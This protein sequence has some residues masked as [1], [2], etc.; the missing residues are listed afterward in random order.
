MNEGALN[1]FALNGPPIS[2]FQTSIVVGSAFAAGTVRLIG[3]FRSPEDF[4]VAAEQAGT[5]GHLLVRNVGVHLAEAQVS[6]TVR[7]VVRSVLVGTA[8]AVGTLLFHATRSAAAIG[9]IIARAF[10]REVVSLD[11]QATG[12][13]T[14]VRF[15][16]E[17]I[18]G[19]ALAD[20][21][22]IPR[23]WVRQYVG[24]QLAALAFAN[25]AVDVIAMHREPAVVDAAVTWTPISRALRRSVV[26]GTAQAAGTVEGDSFFS[27]PF[28]EPALPENTFVVP[29]EPNYFVVT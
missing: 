16:R 27:G 15:A 22:V 14:A 23:S 9:T 6:V 5:M 17:A 13:A 3:F 29:P 24:E 1:G 18:E 12:S 20:G 11:A 28:D 2:V 7:S 8:E 10:R 26:A 21:V 4:Q 19:E 25:G